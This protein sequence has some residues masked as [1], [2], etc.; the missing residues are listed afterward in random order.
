MSIP[1]LWGIVCQSFVSLVFLP[2]NHASAI[3]STYTHYLSGD[4]YVPVVLK[5]SIAFAASC[6][7]PNWW[8]TLE[9]NFDNRR[10]HLARSPVLSHPPLSVSIRIVQHDSSKCGLHISTAHT[11]ARNALCIEL[12]ACLALYTKHDQYSW[13]CRSF[14]LILQ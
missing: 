11:T 14:K 6:L 12:Y 8:H 13:H 3:S 1:S 4:L 2:S 5:R 10:H 7:T 9:S